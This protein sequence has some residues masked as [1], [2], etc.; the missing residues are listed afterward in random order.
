MKV[1]LAGGQK[2]TPLREAILA[3]LNDAG[4]E[5]LDPAASG[6]TD[7]KEYTAWDLQAIQKADAVL[8]FMS[9]DNPS[10]YGVSLEIGY[11]HGIGKRIVFLDATDEDWRHKYFGMA[12]SLSSVVCSPRQAVA[13]L[14]PCSLCGGIGFVAS[15]TDAAYVMAS[16]DDSCPACRP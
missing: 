4:H 15:G 6:L 10:G 14:R 12:R 3:E 2:S 8:A 5:V 1:Y 11:A 9:S 7:E 13:A 16:M